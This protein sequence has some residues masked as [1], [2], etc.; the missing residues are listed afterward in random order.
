MRVN[1][2]PIRSDEALTLSVTGDILV[3]N[4]VAVDLRQD[5]ENPWVQSISRG[6]A[7][8]VTVMLPH[9]PNPPDALAFPQPIDVTADGPVT[10][11]SA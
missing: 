1:F 2:S 10:L 4:G 5:T 11:P 9:G 8:T 7:I 3:I 6:D